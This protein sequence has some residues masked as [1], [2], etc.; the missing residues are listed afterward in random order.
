VEGIRPE[1]LFGRGQ[2]GIDI[3]Y[4]HLRQR[5][6]HQR[7]WS[8]CPDFLQTS[9]SAADPFETLSRAAELHTCFAEETSGSSGV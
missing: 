3:T 9:N 7:V 1:H 2:R 5:D 4:D 8:R 6:R